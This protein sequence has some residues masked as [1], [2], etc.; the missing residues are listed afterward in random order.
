MSV[1]TYFD[2]MTELISAGESRW[3]NKS[4]GLARS[5]GLVK[6]LLENAIDRLRPM[7]RAAAHEPAGPAPIIDAREEMPL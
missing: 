1:L 7:G 5:P 4:G 2:R 6:S 3:R